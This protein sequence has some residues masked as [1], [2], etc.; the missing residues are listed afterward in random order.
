MT[1]T[2]DPRAASRSTPAP[3]H[4]A[5]LRGLVV[6]LG[7]CELLGQ[8]GALPSLVQGGLANLL[9]LPFLAPSLLGAFAC[10]LLLRPDRREA[11]ACA[12][13]AAALAW[14]LYTRVAAD[15]HAL[16]TTAFSALG[17]GSILVLAVRALFARGD[18]RAAVL[19]ALLPAAILPAFVILAQPMTYLT[20]T[21]WPTT[22]DRR[23]YLAD[24]AFGA[25]LA[26]DL[27]RFVQAVPLLGDVCLAVYVALPLA[28]MLVHALRVRAG[29]RSND[30]LVTFVALTV[31]GYFGY[32]AVPVA[33]PVYA[34][35]SQFPGDPPD[36]STLS[37]ARSLVLPMPRNCMPSLHSGWALLVWWN[38]R[39]LAAPARAAASAFLAV[40]LLAT[41]GLGFHY[42]VDLV[43]AFPLTMA[44]QA[45]GTTTGDAALRRRAIAAGLAMTLAWIPFVTWHDG[46][47]AWPAPVLWS[48]AL[49][50]VGASSWLERRV[51]ASRG[52][53][54]A[55]AAEPR[56]AASWTDRAASLALGLVG[57]ATL[58][59]WTIYANALAT[60]LGA[61]NA[62]RA[63]LLVVLGFGAA[64]GFAVAAAM[65]RRGFPPLRAAALGCAALAVAGAVAP[66]LLDWTAATFPETAGG[67]TADALVVE[68][69]RV[70]FAAVVSLPT[71]VAA[72]VALA[73]LA[74]GRT[75]RERQ[76]RDP[77]RRATTVALAA[78]PAAVGAATAAIASAHLMLPSLY[79]RHLP[80]FVAALAAAIAFAASRRETSQA[81]PRDGTR[82]A[83]AALAATFA[84]AFTG[85]G[86]L[87]VASHL[88][89]SVVGRTVQ[90][91]AQAPFLV[92]LGLGSGLLASA[93]L[94]RRG[95]DPIRA[96]VVAWS[97]LA[98]VVV[99]G[100]ALWG[101]VPAYFGTY[102]D[103]AQLHRIASTFAEREFV[104]LCS[105][106]PFVLLPAALVGAALGLAPAGR[107]LPSRRTTAN[108]CSL[109][110]VAIVGMLA[111]AAVTPALLVPMAGS[112]VLLEFAAAASLLLALAPL[113]GIAAEERVRTA[114]IPGVAA[115]ALLLVPRPF[116][117]ARLASPQGLLFEPASSAP[118]IAVAEDAG[119]IATIR[120]PGTLAVDGLPV[121]P[122]GELAIPPLA[123]G[124]DRALVVGLASGERIR[125]L[126][127]SG[128][129]SIVLAGAGDALV[130]LVGD[131]A[132]HA[133]TNARVEVRRAGA[134]G[135]L[136]LEDSTWDLVAID[137]AEASRPEVAS[138]ATREFYSL[139]ALRLSPRG[140]LQQQLD[141]SRLSTL[142]LTS[143]LASARSAFAFVLV[144]FDADTAT[145][146]ACGPACDVAAMREAL[147]TRPGV[148]PSN[149][150]PA[151]AGAPLVPSG[152]LDPPDVERLLV[153]AAGQ[154]GVDVDVI[155][156]TDPDMFLAH[157]APRSFVRKAD[158]GVDSAGMLRQFAA[159]R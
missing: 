39:P 134:R 148:G 135:V 159:A 27:G 108:E 70:A 158:V 19:E 7:V 92:A 107:D 140:V 25:P 157:Q 95:F 20:A 154:L 5:I 50:V 98:V 60:D 35:A 126:L 10:Q 106:G 81:Q 101:N 85:G 4:A 34:F 77:G 66:A 51:Y 143:T 123:A 129:E 76:A 132:D 1:A 86:A 11:A 8:A 153:S 71:A 83:P 15:N 100:L 147:P 18:E 45:W 112:R 105:G 53:D 37:A 63:P 138:L 118:S 67:R 36:P 33:G 9:R 91:A 128:F 113:A 13:V 103:Y 49:A 115:A 111:A 125:S 74:G 38:A 42:A 64:G 117:L 73:A 24:A 2:P 99:A 47:L 84:A 114:W 131:G 145:L 16:L 52:G 30:T 62:L 137:A 152:R 65:G 139:A 6:A 58:L 124:R 72:G 94:R 26:F 122:A 28:L 121:A 23:L 43:A 89:S 149:A 130:G 21:L 141:L 54:A 155:G 32:L 97:A 57:F 93:A 78:G 151:A 133:I 88:F 110:A 116:D 14:P 75:R 119:G 150:D 61:A 79:S 104:R 127:E 29:E 40:T 12:A 17:A 82:P 109:A 44:M 69:L 55:D 59:H 136:L 41:V 68:V 3:G 102:G 144:R 56:A 156:S 96:T 87:A 80:P 120:P 146:V 46:M 48:L 31:V 22:F 90:S 142:A